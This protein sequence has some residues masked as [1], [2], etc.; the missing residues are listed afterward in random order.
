M[1]LRETGEV[2]A[3]RGRRLRRLA[4]KAEFNGIG[5]LRTYIRIGRTASPSRH[6]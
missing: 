1:S 3:E 5:G 4:S 2:E 6:F